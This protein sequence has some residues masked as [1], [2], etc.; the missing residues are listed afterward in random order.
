MTGVSVAAQS[1]LAIRTDGASV[2]MWRS[3]E[4]AFGRGKPMNHPPNTPAKAPQASG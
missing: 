2:A 1:G 4:Q 3:A